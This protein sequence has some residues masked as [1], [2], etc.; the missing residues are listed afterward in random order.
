M[1]F[2]VEY[3]DESEL[4]RHVRENKIWKGVNQETEIYTNLC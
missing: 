1:E 3:L 2:K 4:Q